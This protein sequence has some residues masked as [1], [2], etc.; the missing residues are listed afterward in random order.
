[1]CEPVLKVRRF[2]RLLLAVIPAVAVLT[3]CDS[4]VTKDFSLTIITSEELGDKAT[5][6]LPQEVIDLAMPIEDCSEVTLVPHST[7]Y[8]LGRD[9][10]T[11]MTLETT[12]EGG[13]AGDRTNL[14]LIRREMQKQLSAQE[15]SE[16]FVEPADGL[17]DLTSA[18][19]SYLSTIG[20]ESL[21]IFYGNSSS[22]DGRYEGI[23]SAS[24]VSGVRSLIADELCEGDASVFV[25]LDPPLEIDPGVE[26]RIAQQ[27]DSILEQL[28][29]INRAAGELTDDDERHE[30][31]EAARS[32]IERSSVGTD[33][34]FAYELMKNRIYGEEHHEAFDL[35]MEAARIAVAQDQAAYLL[36]RIN[37]E[38]D[39]D[40]WALSH[41]HPEDWNPIIELLEHNHE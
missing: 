30:A 32:E 36:D 21:G 39:T 22:A 3:G 10:S 5:R 18:L 41:G 13:F 1:M 8:R 14:R 15:V 19:E 4:N 25:F 29:S 37:G 34:R 20:S 2:L 35:L 24:S 31:L 9:R 7:L 6:H 28:D 26:T 11:E 17:I 12:V 16:V 40:L 33:Y 27:T 23:K 38:K